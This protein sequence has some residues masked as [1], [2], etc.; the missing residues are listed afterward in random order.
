MTA[1][2]KKCFLGLC[3][4]YGIILGGLLYWH[5]C[6]NLE[7]HAANPRYYQIFEKDRGPI[8]DRNGTPLAFSQLE[9]GKYRRCYAA[10][11]LSH[12]V[13]YFHQRYGMAGLER[14]Y[15]ADLLAGRT[16]S[17]TLDLAIQQ[18]VE[19]ALEGKTGAA[20]VIKPASGEVLALVSSPYID[21]AN[22][23][24]NWAD[25]QSDLRSPFL[26]RVTNGLYP[27]GSVL[28]PIVYAAALETG[29]TKAKETWLDEGAVIIE[30]KRLANYGQ[31][32]FGTITT[33]E[34][35][36]YSSNVVF[37]GLATAL[38]EELLDYYGLFGLGAQPAW[39][40]GAK[41]GF[42]PAGVKSKYAAA[43]LGIG[44][45]ELLATP[46]QIALVGAAIA[47]RG[48]LV[49]PYLVQELKGGLKMRQI[50]RPQMG[51]PIIS[52]QAA[53]TVRDAM[54]LAVKEGTAKSAGQ[55]DH[56]FAAKTG[57]AQTARGDHA[58]F[59]GFAPAHHPAVCAAVII[60]EGGAGGLVAAPLG[61]AILKGALDI[62]DGKK[63]KR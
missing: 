12:T 47:N 62:V 46:L 11:S 3:L 16:L 24:E 39:E 48:S 34:A 52:E 50:T 5:L 26:N 33:E 40:L 22:L 21:G 57:T 38:G 37:A 60:E 59:V 61:G 25:Y 15:H 42:L 13:G 20:V 44:Q 1:G 9:G 6:P 17:T 28:K 55:K 29:L 8:L 35:L 2:L 36:A 27:P 49:T 54:V 58:W 45:G 23:A 32:A 18:L 53:V 10:S 14:L 56:V 31:K 43:L 51:V 7:K 19:K 4:V 30:N 63:G 41:K